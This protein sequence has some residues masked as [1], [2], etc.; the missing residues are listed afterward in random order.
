MLS[1]MGGA[2]NEPIDLEQ[3]CF[4]RVL[5]DQVALAACQ[6]VGSDRDRGAHACEEIVAQQELCF[7]TF[8]HDP[9]PS[10]TEV[11]IERRTVRYSGE[12]AQRVV[13]ESIVDIERE[14]EQG[15][16]ECSVTPSYSDS[17]SR[18]RAQLSFRVTPIQ[19]STST[20]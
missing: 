1:I 12:V 11:P 20:V 6:S 7:T 15:A 17:R 9:D 2:E 18:R 10:P 16:C 8:G 14:L 19:S 4:P 3:E 13:V 5:N